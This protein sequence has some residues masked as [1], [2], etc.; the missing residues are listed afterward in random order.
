MCSS[1]TGALQE[2]SRVGQGPTVPIRIQSASRAEETLQQLLGYVYGIVYVGY[3][4]V[5]ST[6]HITDFH[7]GTNYSMSH[8]DGHLSRC[9]I[10]LGFPHIQ[11]SLYML[12]CGAK[13]GHKSN[14]AQ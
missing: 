1:S 4:R 7:I 5:Y 9:F 14:E 8:A 12:G 3:F 2:E 13:G 6:E 11:G 10:L